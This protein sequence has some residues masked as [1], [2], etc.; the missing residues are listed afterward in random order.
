MVK[1]LQWLQGYMEADALQCRAGGRRSGKRGLPAK[2][3]TMATVCAAFRR[4]PSPSV[5]WWGKSF[6]CERRERDQKDAKDRRDEQ[7]FA[8]VRF[9]SLPLAWLWGRRL[10]GTL[11]PPK[12][13]SVR[14]IPRYTAFLAGRFFLEAW[15]SDQKGR[16]GCAAGETFQRN[17]STRRRGATLVDGYGRLFGRIFLRL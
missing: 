13:P 14:L 16:K 15:K 17:V 9:R 8:C 1:M 3:V 6:F 12:G 10:A 2:A 4:L 11:A 5:A 7:S